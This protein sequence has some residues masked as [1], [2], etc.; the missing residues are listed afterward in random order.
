MPLGERETKMREYSTREEA[1][2][3]PE[4]NLMYIYTCSKCG[5]EREDYPHCNVGGLCDCGG[6]WQKTGESYNA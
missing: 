3:D 5:A 1:E 6:E 2:M 4:L